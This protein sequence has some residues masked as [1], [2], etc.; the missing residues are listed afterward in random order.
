MQ[1]RLVPGIAPRLLLAAERIGQVE[2]HRQE[3]AVDVAAGGG[4]RLGADGEV[5]FVAAEI[6][7]GA[8]EIEQVEARNQGEDGRDGDSWGTQAY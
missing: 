5:R 2:E 7:R 3:V 6:D 4:D 8:F 1:Q